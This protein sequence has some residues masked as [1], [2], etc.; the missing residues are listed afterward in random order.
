MTCQ[1]SSLAGYNEWSIDSISG[2]AGTS[3][4][5]CA[6]TAYIAQLRPGAHAL[7]AAGYLQA[8]APLR[9]ADKCFHA[10]R[11]P[12]ASRACIREVQRICNGC[13]CTLGSIVACAQARCEHFWEVLL[14][15][16]LVWHVDHGHKQD[17]LHHIFTLLSLQQHAVSGGRSRS[18]PCL[19]KL[20]HK[21]PLCRAPTH[22]ASD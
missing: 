1:T 19:H 10:W 3:F 18:R 11:Q 4:A 2:L 5:V 16:L 12:S 13:T 22:R 7:L 20:L 21:H 9:P 17:S 6:D 14:M 15:L 8:L